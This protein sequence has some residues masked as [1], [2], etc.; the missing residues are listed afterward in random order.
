MTQN[1][2][3]FQ[4]PEPSQ[5]IPGDPFG[6]MKQPRQKTTPP[7]QEVNR[8]HDRSDV[9]SSWAAQHHTIGV[10]H[11]QAAAG[12]HKHDGN[13]SKLLLENV[14]ITGASNSAVISSIIDALVQLG[15]T[16][17]NTAGL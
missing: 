11:D 3:E 14:T 4:Y 7:P 12:D 13:N 5:V 10:K 6:P 17:S 1:P 16:D 2:D 8:F 15:A 9:D